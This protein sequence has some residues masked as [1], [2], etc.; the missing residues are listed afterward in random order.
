[1]RLYRVT[2]TTGVLIPLLTAAA[3]AQTLPTPPVPAPAIIHPAGSIDMTTAIP[4]P[5]S[6]TGAMLK[7]GSVPPPDPK[8]A[9][10]K[11]PDLTYGRAVMQLLCNDRPNGDDSH[12]TGM[13]KITRCNLG[14]KIQDDQAY[15]PT[16]DDKKLIED[17]ISLWPALVGREII[18]FVAPED[19]K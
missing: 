9:D 3:L 5:M 17:H 8:P 1:M 10:W 4:M 16:T 12:E 11:Q 14:V 2:L 13:A 6:T 18:K 15:K 7:D 19:S